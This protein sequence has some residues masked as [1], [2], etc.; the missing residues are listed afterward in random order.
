MTWFLRRFWVAGV[1]L[2]LLAAGWWAIV[3]STVVINGYLTLPQA[4]V[5]LVFETDAC[6]MAM[7][8][9]IVRN[10]HLLEMTEYSPNLLWVGLALL[11][12]QLALYPSLPPNDPLGLGHEND[13]AAQ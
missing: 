5:C 12:A 4:A 11:F 6:E 3:F 10:R 2:L 8:L 13:R 9:C 7:S 1:G